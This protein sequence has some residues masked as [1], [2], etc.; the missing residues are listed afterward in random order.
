MI[1]T[2]THV[3]ELKLRTVKIPHGKSSAVIRPLWKTI[4]HFMW[5]RSLGAAALHIRL[6]ICHMR[7]AE[8][9]PS[10]RSQTKE[11]S[12]DLL[13]SSE[14][15]TEERYRTFSVICTRKSPNEIRQKKLIPE[16]WHKLWI[17]SCL[18]LTFYSKPTE[19][20]LEQVQLFQVI[21]LHYKISRSK[22]HL[23]S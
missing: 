11:S 21:V 7:S 16:G 23:V 15:H 8:N 3:L 5:Y 19:T 6:E 12:P 14:T 17:F 22:C 4:T 18:S 20:E 1:H 10:G 13:I 2:I 9:I